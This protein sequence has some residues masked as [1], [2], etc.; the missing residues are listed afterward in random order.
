MTY[1]DISSI[2]DKIAE[3]LNS[4]TTANGYPITAGCFDADRITP[5][6]IAR[7]QA[8]YQYI[9]M[10][11]HMG[12]QF[13]HETLDHT[14]IAIDNWL[15]VLIVDNPP[16]SDA[17]DVFADCVYYVFMRE[18]TLDGLVSL[19]RVENVNK[20]DAYFDIEGVDQASIELITERI[21][22]PV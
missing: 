1:K 6:Y 7:V 11:K 21:L 16:D 20:V 19:L 2:K 17:I 12:T 14:A 8:Q 18:K 10:F 13:D 9:A 3:R 4:I 5:D 15:I 22:D